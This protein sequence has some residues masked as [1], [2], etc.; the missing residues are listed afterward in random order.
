MVKE[1]MSVNASEVREKAQRLL[2]LAEK[3]SSNDW[4]AKGRHDYSIT[5]RK[6]TMQFT[7]PFDFNDARFI[8]AARNDAPPLAKWVLGACP[9]N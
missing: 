9:S 3:V 7:I 6:G 5:G 4:V 1:N 8:A 2:E